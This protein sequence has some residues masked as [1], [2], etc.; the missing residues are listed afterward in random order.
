MI[1][2]LSEYIDPPARELLAQHATIVDNFNEIEKIDAILLRNIPVTAQ[3]MDKAKNLKLIAKH[4]IGVN[5]IDLEAARA[6]GIIVTNTPTAN[7]DSV[8]ELVVATILN[9][10]RKI[11]QA[12]IGCR[13]GK[14]TKIAPKE[15][16][17]NEIG[18]KVLGQI[19][20]G[21]IAQRAANILRNGFKMK[22]IAYDPFIDAEEAKKRGFEKV[23]TLEELIKRA[24]VVNVSVHLTK[25]TV[26]LISG[27]MFDNF[28]KNAILIN[29]SRGGIVNEDDLYDALKAGKLKGAACDTFVHEPPSAANSKLFELDNF[30][31]TPHL[32]ADTEEAL[33]KV[34]REAVQEIINLATGKAP[35]HRVC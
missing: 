25:D 13:A 31:G 30:C 15:L 12:N 23:E 9:L 26:D 28:K 11:Y 17:G 8:A 6:H 32:G 2:Y 5:T 24:D 1:V 19:G 29:A 18:G 33:Q 14:Y 22:T 21:N 20:V 34:G 27:K 10:E 35:I 3:M 4:G 7:A 16:E